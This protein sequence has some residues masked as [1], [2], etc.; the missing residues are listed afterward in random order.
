MSIYSLSAKSV[1][2]VENMNP[3]SSPSIYPFVHSSIYS[4]IPVLRQNSL[5]N[6]TLLILYCPQTC[7]IDVLDKAHIITQSKI[8]HLQV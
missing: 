7:V 5:N 1:F 2:L 6:V 3:F 8:S 4:S